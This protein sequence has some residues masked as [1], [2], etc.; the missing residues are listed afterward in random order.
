MKN[1]TKTYLI[2]VCYALSG[3]CIYKIK[4]NDINH[5]IGELY[6][7]S[8]EQIGCVYYNIY[9]ETKE[10]FLKNAGYSIITLIKE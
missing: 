9:T 5:V 2:Y 8:I 1:E 7:K 6:C 3:T 4:T 10:E